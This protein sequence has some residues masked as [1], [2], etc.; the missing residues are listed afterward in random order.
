MEIVGDCSADTAGW[1]LRPLSQGGLYRRLR[2]RA[3]T[4]GLPL[5]RR[6]NR[7]GIAAVIEREFFPEVARLP[8]DDLAMNHPINPDQLPAN[9][10]PTRRQLLRSGVAASFAAASGGLLGLGYAQTAKVEMPQA[11]ELIRGKDPRLQTLSSR[12]VVLETPLELLLQKRIVPT[13]WLFIRN[14]ASPKGFDNLDPAPLRGWA[15]QVSGLVDRL[16]TIPAERLS[17]LP[18]V[19]HEMVLQ[20]SGAGRALFSRAAQTK[21]TQ[22]GRGGF[23]NVKF[24]GV[25]LSKVFE[26]W[27]IRIKPGAQFLTAE[28]AD[29]PLAGNEDFE[30]SIPLNDAL[31]FT[32]LALSLNGKP[33]PAAHGGPIRL[34]TPGVY[35]TMNIKWLT[36]LRLEASETSNY[37]H[38]PR[39][40]VPVEPIKRGWDYEYTL[41]NS[42]PTYL[43]NVKSVMLK[44]TEGSQVTA[45][46][47]AVE[48]VA[49]NDGRA[50]LEQ[51]LVSADGGQSWQRSKLEKPSGPFGWYRWTTT[52]NLQRG[53]AELWSRAIDTWGRSQPLDGS[54]F[55]NPRGYEWNGV[56]RIPVTVI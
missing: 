1:L 43:M 34:I 35:A 32:L 27:G 56:E 20:C 55:W 10:H 9:P 24:G 6:P 16:V 21:G 51:V 37:N 40:R 44:P 8:K 48:G 18:Q 4:P 23:G 31:D 19:E 53:K 42:R 5:R 49:F 25:K 28:G 39:Y 15:V 26:T 17:E 47:V 46:Q 45:G 33:I 13:E 38:I 29:Q 2:R 7:C 30:H 54:V 11:N 12:P 3:T 14:N 52:V 22:W 41:R 36:R 50:P